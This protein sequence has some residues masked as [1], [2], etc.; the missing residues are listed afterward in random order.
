MAKTYEV[1]EEVMKSQGYDVKLEGSGK[2]LFD[3]VLGRFQRAWNKFRL[4]ISVVQ[5][6]GNLH[7][8]SCY[9]KHYGAHPWGSFGDV[10]QYILYIYTADERR[11]GALLPLKIPM[12]SLPVSCRIITRHILY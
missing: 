9:E 12:D 4:S 6:R 8:Y 7:N 10:F 5:R 1:I 11:R 2:S 3:N